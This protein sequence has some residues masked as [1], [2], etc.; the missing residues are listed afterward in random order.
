[1]PEGLHLLDGIGFLGLLKELCDVGFE[2]AFAIVYLLK[3]VIME[4]DTGVEPAYK[5]LQSSA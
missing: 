1:M 4:D 2:A 3:L 5:D